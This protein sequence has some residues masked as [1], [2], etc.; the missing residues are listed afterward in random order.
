MREAVR[1][2]ELVENPTANLTNVLRFFVDIVWTE[3]RP[4]GIAANRFI[5]LLNAQPNRTTVLK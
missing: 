2:G 1:D 5:E 3:E 4:L